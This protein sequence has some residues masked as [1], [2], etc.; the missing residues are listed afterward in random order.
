MKKDPPAYL[1]L[2]E[3]IREEIL[4]GIRPYGSRLPSRRVLA[5][6]RGVS[7]VTVDHSYELLCEEGYAES[8]PKS[9]YFV[10]YR[11]EDGFSLPV[12]LPRA[13][14]PSPVL[15]GSRDSFPFPTLARVMRR[16]LTDYGEWILIRPPNTGC[17][18]LREALCRYLARNRG[19]RVQ[20]DQLVIGA[21]AEYLYGLVVELLGPRRTYG[22]EAPSYKKIEQVYRAR[23][24]RL[25][26]CSLGQDGIM[27]EA[28][29]STPAS[30]LHITP[31]RSF[32]SG[33]TASA[34]KRREYLRWV[35]VPDR[36]LVEDD[37]ESEFS[38]LR[39]PEETLFAM[40][41]GRNVLYLNTFSR[42]VSPSLRVGYMVIPRDLLPAFELRLGFYS[43]TVPAFEQYVLTE[44]LNSGDFERH[45]NRIR[46]LDRTQR[47]SGGRTA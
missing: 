3:T 42:T 26:F 15:P 17:P 12:R 37:Y 25:D 9:G 24:V 43:C 8:R 39:K 33:V 11:E 2:Y 46:R 22:I 19:I 7:A 4:S 41:K 40:S 36:Y 47:S 27:T 30:V 29:R 6:D 13:A 34:S 38:L 45:I 23:G 21:G 5:R 44:L 14:A 16:V 31:F 35:S 32:P 18:E 20:S 10:T 28:L 1:S